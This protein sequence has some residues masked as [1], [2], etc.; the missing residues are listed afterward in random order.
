MMMRRLHLGAEARLA[1]GRHHLLGAQRCRRRRPAARTAC[2]R[3]WRGWR[4]TRRAGSGSRSAGRRHGG[5]R[6][7][8]A[9]S[10]PRDAS[11]LD[12]LVEALPQPGARS[13][14]RRDSDHHADREAGHLPGSGRGDDRS[15]TG[16]SMEV[17]SHGVVSGD[18]PWCS[19]AASRTHRA[20]AGARAGRGFEGERDQAV[21]RRAAVGR[22]RAHRSGRRRRLPDG[23]SGVAADRQRGLERPPGL[24]QSRRPSRRG[25]AQRSQG[26][27]GRPVRGVLGGGTAVANSSMLV[28][29]RSPGHDREGGGSR[30]RRTAASS[31]P[32][33][34]RPQVVE[35]PAVE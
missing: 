26:V 8:R 1:G 10:A 27:T 22:R 18:N 28:L 35:L 14:R 9:I 11:Q 25:S 31:R 32:R 29:P 15:G 12:R 21:A 33:S 13:P 19:R 6:T 34:W 3:T 17:E 2:R 16:A 23:P 30:S 5:G 7:P 4:S 20:G 24:P